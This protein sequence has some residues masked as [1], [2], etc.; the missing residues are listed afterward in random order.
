MPL[1]KLQS[2]TN[3]RTLIQNLEDGKAKWSIYTQLTLQIDHFAF[4][5]SICFIKN[6]IIKEPLEILKIIM[7]KLF[8]I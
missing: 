7:H 4:P 6:N 5:P 8:Y 3:Q 1:K 2:K